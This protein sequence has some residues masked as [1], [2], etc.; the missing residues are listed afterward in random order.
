MNLNNTQNAL[1]K[2]A[3]C[4]VADQEDQMAISEKGKDLDSY[5][6]ARARRD[7]CQKIASLYES[8]WDRHILILGDDP[9]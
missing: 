2:F 9:R 1:L 6:M 5:M 3:K 7:A 8:K 4:E